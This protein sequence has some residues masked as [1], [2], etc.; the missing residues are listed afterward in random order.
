MEEKV[1]TFQKLRVGKEPE[2]VVLKES[3]LDKGGVYEDLL[4]GELERKWESSPKIVQ[5]RFASL[6]VKEAKKR[7]KSTLKKRSK[8]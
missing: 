7:L 5:D 2:L 3:E 4:L 6:R 1:F 8:N